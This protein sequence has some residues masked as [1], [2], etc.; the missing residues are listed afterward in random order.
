HLPRVSPLWDM[1]QASY[2]VLNT[3]NPNIT[4]HF[5]LRYD[6]QPPFYEA[7]GVEGR[8]RKANGTN[9]A[10]CLWSEESG[11]KQGMTMSQVSGKGKCIG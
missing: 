1:L 7:T 11:R 4:E 10:Q 8:L 3:T 5:W 2:Q 9:P 6:I